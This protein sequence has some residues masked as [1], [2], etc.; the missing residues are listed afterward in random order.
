MKVSTAKLLLFDADLSSSVLDAL[1]LIEKSTSSLLL[2]QWSDADC[3]N[4]LVQ[5]NVRCDLVTDNSLGR[6]S[7]EP[8]PDIFRQPLVLFL[9]LA[10]IL[11]RS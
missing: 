9:V 8:I 1:P 10:R 3:L 4:P 6:M 7:T 2:A 11:R 5:L